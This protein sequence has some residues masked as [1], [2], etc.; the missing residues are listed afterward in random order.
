MQICSDQLDQLTEAAVVDLRLLLAGDVS[1]PRSPGAWSKLEILGHLVDSA[2]NNHHRFVRA[3]ELDELKFPPYDP[4]A[5]VAAQR[6]RECDWDRLVD[7]WLAYNRHL[8]HVLRVMPDEQLET[9][10]WVDWYDEPRTIPLRTVVDAYIEHIAGHL[11]Q[12]RE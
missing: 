3:Q 8:V 1:T 4:P 6:Y 12:L 5:W 11:K 9:P 7:L 2:A 10:C